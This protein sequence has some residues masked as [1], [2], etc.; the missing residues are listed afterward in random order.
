MKEKQLKNKRE[1]VV[2]DTVQNTQKTINFHLVYFCYQQKKTTYNQEH[3]VNCFLILKQL[4]L[5]F[6]IV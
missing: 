3:I 5:L 2:V 4:L 1:I 6:V